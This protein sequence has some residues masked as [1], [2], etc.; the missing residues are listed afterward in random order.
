MTSCRYCRDVDP[1]P[2][3][4]PWDGE[5]A[6][7]GIVRLNGGCTLECTCYFDGGHISGGITVPVSFCPFCGRDLRSEE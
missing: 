1:E 7:M 4:E 6:D 3:S 2:I 5:G